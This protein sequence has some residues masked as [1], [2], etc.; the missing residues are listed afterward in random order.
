MDIIEETVEPNCDKS[1]RH[2]SSNVFTSLLTKTLIMAAAYQDGCVTVW[3]ITA[4]SDTATI[5]HRLWPDCRKGSIHELKIDDSGVR[6]AACSKDS[7]KDRL[8]VFDVGSAE[9]L[10]VRHEPVPPQYLGNISFS[11]SGDRVAFTANDIDG[12][13]SLRILDSATGTVLCTIDND[14]GHYVLSYVF[15]DDDRLIITCGRTSNGEPS[16]VRCWC[17]FSG[18]RVLGHWTESYQA[19]TVSANYVWDKIFFGHYAYGYGELESFDCVGSQGV[20]HYSGTA[21]L[22]GD[23]VGFVD[24]NSVASVQWVAAASPIVTAIDVTTKNRTRFAAGTSQ[25]L[26]AVRGVVS[27]A[28]MILMSQISSLYVVLARWGEEGEV[29]SILTDSLRSNSK[30]LSACGVEPNRVILM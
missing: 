13:G 4:G 29:L 10:F 2:C 30:I 12:Y 27:G 6:L 9:L 8:F 17:A 14:D 16:A 23:V 22:P 5:K 11:R 25:R 3:E 15:V 24:E 26:N 20:L 7:G 19:T 1:S 28:P 18:E 21:Y